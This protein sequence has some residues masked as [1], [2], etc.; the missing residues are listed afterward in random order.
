[1]LNQLV[2]KV[3]NCTYAPLALR[4]VLW[5]KPVDSTWVKMADTTCKPGRSTMKRKQVFTA[6]DVLIL[7]CDKELDDEGENEISRIH[8]QWGVASYSG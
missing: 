5:L 7:F 6:E 2:P 8:C 3:R 4:N 1:M